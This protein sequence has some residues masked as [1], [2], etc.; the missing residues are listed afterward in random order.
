MVRVS[1]T[2]TDGHLYINLLDFKDEVE[3][4]VIFEK[5]Q[6]LISEQRTRIKVW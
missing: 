3:Q 1:K 2:N 5:I 6:K 4:Q